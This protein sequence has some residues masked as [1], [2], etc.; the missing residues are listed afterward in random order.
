[1]WRSL[2]TI[3]RSK[4]P[5]S[6]KM[7]DFDADQTTLVMAPSAPS[8]HSASLLVQLQ[9][10]DRISSPNAQ[11]SLSMSANPTQPS[12]QHVIR[13]QERLR[14]TLAE[15]HQNRNYQILVREL[16]EATIPE[17]QFA[18]RQGLDADSLT[19]TLAEETA[20]MY[21]LGRNHWEY[22]KVTGVTG[23]YDLQNIVRVT[24]YISLFSSFID[25]GLYCR[26]AGFG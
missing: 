17:S 9:E 14:E 11:T 25:D 12:S 19:I 15:Q 13:A 4:H 3:A 22:S 18:E 24:P 8:Q 2:K 7:V 16:L 21:I 23:V 5:D 26:T 20:E 10:I 6:S 1:M